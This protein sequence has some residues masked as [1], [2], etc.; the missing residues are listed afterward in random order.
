MR[1]NHLIVCLLTALLGA[2]CTTEKFPIQINESFLEAKAF[3]RGNRLHVS[4]GKIDREWELTAAG[5][6]TKTVENDAQRPSTTTEGHLADWNLTGI[7]SPDT[8]G[9]LL[10]L[11]AQRANDEG[12]TSEH[13][14]VVAEF[15]YP[16]QGIRLKYVIWAYPKAPGMRTQLFVKKLANF[17]VPDNQIGNAR[18]EYLPVDTEGVT[19]KLIGYYNHTQRRN[20]S[21]DEIL[22]EEI[23]KGATD[24][25]WPSIIDLQSGNDG[26]MLIQE[27]HKCVNQSG[28]NTG[29]FHIDDY[30]VYASG[31]GIGAGDLTNEY[32]PIWAYW[33]I[34]YKGDDSHRQLALKE[35][36]RIRYPIDSKRDIYIMANNWGSGSTKDESLYASREANILTEIQSQKDLGID[37]QQVDDGWQ[38]LQYKTWDDVPT[39]NSKQFGQYDVYPEGWKNI[40]ASAKKEGIRLGLWAA[41]GIPGEDLLR[42]YKTGGFAYYKLDFANLDTYEK[43]HG[44]VDKVRTFILATDH[45]ARVNWDVTENPA[46][47]GYFFGREYGNIYLENR[48]PINPP[49]VLYHPYL[50]LRDTWQVAKY[51][52]LNKFQISIQNIDRVNRQLSDAHLHNHPYSVAIALMGSPIFF[53]ETRY[54]SEEARDQIRPVLKVYKTHRDEM[55]KGFVFPIGEKPDN[56]SWPGFQNYNPDTDSGYLMVFREI[57]NREAA[58]SMKL[59]FIKNKTL[60]LTNV[61]T[62]TTEHK[63]VDAEGHIDLGIADAADFRF[64]KYEIK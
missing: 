23:T 25:Q 34:A 38:G 22:K 16:E 5:L 21:K 27:S 42:H 48:K 36:D 18:A 15:E 19:T 55:Y 46:R 39:A 41:W 28:V 47:I 24:F 61:M 14:E 1:P 43:F 4:T 44:L 17:Q 6:L 37:V 59:H 64:Y 26:L 53:Q 11:S 9:R 56:A 33:L 2:A 10:G 45:K 12:F 8:K 40:K 30:G 54:Y 62:G 35:F 52:N 7:L 13:L 63:K 58:K 57:N 3:T 20:T 31:L 32:R 60:V 49:H 51:T 29:G 50:V